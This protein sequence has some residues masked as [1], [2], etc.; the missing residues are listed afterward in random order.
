MG[1]VFKFSSKPEKVIA[2]VTAA[3]VLSI[4]FDDHKRRERGSKRYKSFPKRVRKNYTRVDEIL[5]KTL[6]KELYD[7]KEHFNDEV[8]EN[9]TIENGEFIKL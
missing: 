2:A 9:L 1:M 5:K 7:G 6:A 8:L 3:V 4:I